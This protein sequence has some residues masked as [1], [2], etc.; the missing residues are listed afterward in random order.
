MLAHLKTL[1]NYVIC[2]LVFDGLRWSKMGLDHLS[3][4][5][6]ILEHERSS[7]MLYMDG[8]GWDGILNYV[9]WRL[10]TC[11]VEDLRM[12]EGWSLLST[13]VGGFREGGGERGG[14]EGGCGYKRGTLKQLVVATLPPFESLLPILSFCHTGENSHNYVTILK[15]PS[16]VQC[17]FLVIMGCCLRYIH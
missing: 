7:S 15:P 14:R 3:P 12:S 13:V 1:R 11:S 17:P 6:C 2:F 9:H 16:N 5:K 8:M 10:F 4:Y